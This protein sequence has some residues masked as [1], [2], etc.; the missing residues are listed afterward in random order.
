[1]RPS[2]CDLAPPTHL[3]TFDSNGWSPI[4]AIPLEEHHPVAARHPSHIVPPLDPQHDIRSSDRDV[5]RALLARSQGSLGALRSDPMFVYLIG[6][7][8]F[9]SSRES[10]PPC[11]LD[12]MRVDVYKI[13]S[14]SNNLRANHAPTYYFDLLRNHTSKGSRYDEEIRRDLN[15]T[16]PAIPFFN[17]H[18]QDA[19]REATGQRGGLELLRRILTGYA[20]RN[21][22]LGYCQG[23]NLLGALLL[24]LTHQS[25]LQHITILDADHDE[26]EEDEEHIAQTI[27]NDPISSDLTPSA[28]EVECFWMFCCL[29]ERRLGYY[30]KSMCGLEVDQRVFSCLVSSLLPE[31]SA[32]LGTHSIALPAIS[33]SWFVCLFVEAPFSISMHPSSI[34]RIYTLWDALMLHGDEALFGV[35]LALLKSLE[36]R[37][38]A[39]D[40]PSEL[41]AL[42]L[43]AAWRSDEVQNQLNPTNLLQVAFEQFG[44][45]SGGLAF[46]IA[47]LRDVHRAAVLRE[48]QV[49]HVSHANHLAR[50]L[51]FIPPHGETP[52]SKKSP[53]DGAKE[54]QRLWAR[55]LQADGWSVLLYG[56]LTPP[57]AITS[58]ST[59]SLSHTDPITLSRF[60]QV[61]VHHVFSAADV[62]RWCGREVVGGMAGRLFHAVAGFNHNA[63]TNTG[64]SAVKAK[65]AA[66]GTPH[67]IGFESFLAAT[68]AFNA[69]TSD[70]LDAAPAN[71]LS[72]QRMRLAFHFFDVDRDGWVGV[73]ELMGGLQSIHALD[74]GCMVEY[75]SVGGADD[76]NAN[77]NVT[78]D[79]VEPFAESVHSACDHLFTLAACLHRESMIAAAAKTADGFSDTRQLPS[80]QF[81]FEALIDSG[82]DWNAFRQVIPHHEATRKLFRLN[83]PNDAHKLIPLPSL[84]IHRPTSDTSS[85]ANG[86]STRSSRLSSRASKD[87][88][89][90]RTRSSSTATAATHLSASTSSPCPPSS[91]F[92]SPPAASHPSLTPHALTSSSI[93]S[94]SRRNSLIVLLSQ[95]QQQQH[96]AMPRKMTDSTGSTLTPSSP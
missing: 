31:L 58:Q 16:M 33:V 43:P 6:S 5:W 10:P 39:M 47:T 85:N 42:L 71:S 50:S 95:Q 63:S 75:E 7:D 81:V 35:S 34:R 20:M 91:T 94:T 74:H 8:P 89:G 24:I 72:E 66:T 17:P 52:D 88:E 30:C 59:S 65:Y 1:M 3:R 55:F 51:S 23:M 69:S 83:Q 15:R 21:P 54:V 76:A 61:F 12:E 87:E 92:A 77:G 26:D 25:K 9:S 32:H 93:S 37:V 28:E 49:L 84:S 86:H 64:K 96:P 80:V 19:I 79:V 13:L 27:V 70:S 68:Y 41:L 2:A 36:P 57:L 46:Q 73:D 29:V 67:A 44:C 38:L 62:Q 78:E 60:V 11:I 4:D 40:D 18:N 53:T 56:A 22:L 48:G 90:S 14:G 45:D 82:L